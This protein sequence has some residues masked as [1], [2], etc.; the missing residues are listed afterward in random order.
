MATPF[1]GK[2]TSKNTMKQFSGHENSSYGLKQQGPEKLF[3]GSYPKDSKFW[4]CDILYILLAQNIREAK[5]ERLWAYHKT[6]IG[7]WQMEISF[8]YFI[9]GKK[10][11]RKMN[12]NLITYPHYKI[13][14]KK[15]KKY[16]VELN[17][18]EI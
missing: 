2:S 3:G 10:N 15:C 13:F 8:P 12:D 17:K 4:V 18:T 16:G 6:G 14:L 11:Q 9:W 1:Y 5:K 7:A